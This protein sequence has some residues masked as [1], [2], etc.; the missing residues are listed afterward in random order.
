MCLCVCAL[1]HNAWALAFNVRVYVHLCVSAV[2]V[3]FW[4]GRVWSSFN[5]P[6]VYV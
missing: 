6:F 5:V 4:R 3:Q 1:V 2:R